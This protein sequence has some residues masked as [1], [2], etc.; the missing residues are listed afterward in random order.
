ME[1][2]LD[3]MYMA[4]QAQRLNRATGLRAPVVGRTL[5]RVKWKSV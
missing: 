1:A 2:L 5:S 4:W 3:I